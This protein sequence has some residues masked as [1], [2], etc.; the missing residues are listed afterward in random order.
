[1]ADV[2]SESGLQF[3]GWCCA[4][5]R[6]VSP[7]LGANSRWPCPDWRRTDIVVTAFGTGLPPRNEEAKSAA[8]KA[9]SRAGNRVRGPELSVSRYDIMDADLIYC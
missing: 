7:R 2:G 3:A 1:M 5:P 8:W 6:L 9:Q 4:D